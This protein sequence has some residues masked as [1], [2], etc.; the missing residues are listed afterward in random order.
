MYGLDEVG[1]IPAIISDIKH[2]GDVN[3]FYG[4]KLPIF[5]AP[6]TCIL[7]PENWKTFNDSSV[8]PIYPVRYDEAR[9]VENFEENDWSALTL[10]EF[11]HYFNACNALEKRKYHI[12]IDVANGH[13]QELYTCVRDAKQEY[14]DNLIV[15]IGNIAN[16]EAY[17][18]C[19]KARVDYVRVGIGGGSGCTTSVQTGIHAS[20]PYIL[21]GIDNIKR[22]IRNHELSASFGGKHNNREIAAIN[23]FRTKVV[24][25][26]GITTISRAIKALA[27]GA[28]YVMMGRAFA[29]CKEACGVTLDDG[30]RRMYY[31]QSSKEGQMDRFG[32][33]KANPE[34]TAIWV[35]VTTNLEEFTTKFAAALRSA[36]SYCGAHNLEEFIG[37]VK[38]EYMSPVE[39]Q[40]YNK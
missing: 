9:N 23:G 17:L 10:D 2:R 16:P 12:L 3:P 39:F 8:I 33:V 38:Y 34:G 29:E 21:E 35:D 19:C 1:L 37:K 4:D 24:A 26:G 30:Y 11:K 13:M 40:A 31:G 25:D 27:M 6:M 28:D 5:V 18:E 14:G 22:H 36:M 20:M 7:G 32:K 15:M